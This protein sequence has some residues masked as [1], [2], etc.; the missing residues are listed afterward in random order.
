MK[1]RSLTTSTLSCA[2]AGWISARVV[3]PRPCAIVRTDPNKLEVFINSSKLDFDRTKHRDDA[4]NPT[5]TAGTPPVVRIGLPLL[6]RESWGLVDALNSV[7][8]VRC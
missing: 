3:P 7:L 1:F 4:L 2:K 8:W 5:P 6:G